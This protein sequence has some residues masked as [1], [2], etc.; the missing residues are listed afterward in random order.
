MKILIFIVIIVISIVRAVNRNKSKA[1]KSTGNASKS[2]LNEVWESILEE[3]E[4]VKE[5]IVDDFFEQEKEE[6]EIIAEPVEVDKK[7]QFGYRFSA[8]E[9][10][11]SDIKEEVDTIKLATKKR[12]KILDKD[13][14]LK[15]AIIYSEVI[16]RKYI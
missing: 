13:F 16:N 1:P 2:T 12:K 5:D 8:Q 15:K 4:V 6:Q 9:E 7:R 14:S 10:G 11:T 3:K